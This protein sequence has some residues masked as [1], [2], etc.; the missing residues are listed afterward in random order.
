MGDHNLITSTVLSDGE[1][2]TVELHVVQ[3][4]TDDLESSA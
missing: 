3:V 4:S 2:T 1:D